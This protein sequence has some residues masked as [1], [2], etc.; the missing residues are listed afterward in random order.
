MSE[1]KREQ[2]QRQDFVDNAIHDLMNE[3]NPRED[4]IPWD[5]EMIA[6]VREALRQVIVERLRL[7]DE[8]TFYPYEE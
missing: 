6:S 3:V 7:C 5:I 8:M 4:P 2:I 1:L